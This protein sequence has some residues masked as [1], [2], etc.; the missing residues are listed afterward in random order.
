MGRPQLTF[1]RR[2][3]AFRYT[4]KVGHFL[5]VVLGAFPM[6]ASSFSLVPAGGSLAPRKHAIDRNAIS[7]NRLGYHY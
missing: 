2:R 6:V 3:V 5:L 1:H 4:S 7:L